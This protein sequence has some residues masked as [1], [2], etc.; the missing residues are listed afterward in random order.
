MPDLS[1][2]R[3]SLGGLA[4]PPPQKRRARRQVGPLGGGR[5]L[6]SHSLGDHP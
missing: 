4:A 5:R 1:N 2:A 3:I 6:A